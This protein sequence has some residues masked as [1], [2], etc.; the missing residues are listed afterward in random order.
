MLGK[1]TCLFDYAHR[2]PVLGSSREPVRFHVWVRWAWPRWRP[3]ASNGSGGPAVSLRGGL[4]LAGVLVALSI[5]I[6]I[7]IYAR[8]GASRRDGPGRN[9]SPRFRWLGRE[10]IVGV[11]RTAVLAALAWWVART[12]VRTGAR[13]TRRLAAILPLLVL[14]DLL[15]AHIV[16]VPRWIPLL[17]RA[18]RSGPSLEVR[19]R[20]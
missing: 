16:D 5:P 10:L 20:V 8:S 11:I 6:M 4:I 18:T 12:A 2:I 3:L 15:G 17:D 7:Y 14:A 19:P 1:F 13:P 9:I